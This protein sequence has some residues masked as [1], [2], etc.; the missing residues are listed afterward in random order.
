MVN[1]L[2]KYIEDLNNPSVALTDGLRGLLI[3]ASRLKSTPLQEWIKN[4]LHGYKPGDQ[5]PSYRSSSSATIR[6]RF[7]GGSEIYKIDRTVKLMPSDISDDALSRPAQSL[8]IRQSIA[9]ISSLTQGESDPTIPLP[10]WWIKRYRELADERK[11]VFFESLTLEN[12]QIIVTKVDLIGL[13]DRVRTFAIE[14]ALNVEDIAPKA[15][16]TGGPTV[17]DSPTI[18]RT[19]N[20]FITYVYG[21]VFSPTA[22]AE[23]HARNIQN[24]NNEG[25]ATNSLGD[26]NSNTQES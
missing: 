6:L 2:A 18:E 24:N 22:N 25:T 17:D 16:E 20:N 9:E 3:V 8:D 23:V 10:I 14:M 5:V 19:I 13:L 15:G 4:E 12:A 1:S 7:E 26:A 11:V 21:G